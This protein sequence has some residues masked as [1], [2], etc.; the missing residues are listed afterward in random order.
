VTGDFGDS[1]RSIHAGLPE[2]AEG[3]PFLPGPVFAGPF[4]SGGDPADSPFVYS[5][6][7]NP[8]WRLYEDAIGALEGGHAV[9]FGSG[10]GAYTTLLLGLVSAGDILVLPADGYFGVR[11][12]TAGLLESFDIDVRLVPSETGELARA[13]A[14]AKLVIVET[15]TNPGLDVCD[16][17]VV[18]E[19]AA[20]AGAVLAVDNSLATPLGQRPLELGAD[21]SIASATKG[22]SG[23]SDILLGYVAARDAARADEVR[24]WRARTGAVAGPFEVWLA[25][26]SLA[27]LELRHRR[28]CE[29]AQALAEFLVDRPEVA[30]VRYP[31]L[32]SDPSHELAARQMKYFG[33]VVCFD[34]P[35]K[36]QAQT[37]L[38]SLN[39]VAGATSFGGL[40][41]TAERRG[42]WGSDDIAEG[43]IRFSVGGEDAD[44][45]IADVEQALALARTPTT[46]A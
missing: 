24:S 17:A 36:E 42:R 27:T 29:N 28:Q 25:H 15:P 4:H 5:R 45:L 33:A 32:E 16:I 14:G 44:D 22:T 7:G 21:F 23:H 40:H 3:N 31:G 38:D 9:V 43:R 39:L 37:F 12:L 41:S 19:A 46:V 11:S 34:L 13:A 20:A 8:T 26:R 35:R 2:P 1:T 30:D 6:Q 18:A 10:M